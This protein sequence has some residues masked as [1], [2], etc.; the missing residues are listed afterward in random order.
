VR[1]RFAAAAALLLLGACT[2]PEPD[3]DERQAYEAALRDDSPAG[4]AADTATPAAVL[5]PLREAERASGGTMG[6]AAIHLPTGR[7]IALHGGDRF[8]MASTFKLAVALA[9]LARVDSGRIR[10]DQPVTIVPADFRLGPQPLA[11]SVGRRGGTVTV[12]QM[13]RSM[14]VYSDNLA[15]DKLM[16]MAGGPAAVDAHLRGRGIDGI[17][18]DRYEAEVHW[19]YAGVRHVPPEAEW[20]LQRFDSVTSAVPPAQKDSAHAAF[21]ADPRDTATPDAFVQL[22]G[23]VAEGRGLSAASRRF[24]LD[25]MQASVTGLRRIRGSLPESTTVA[26]KTGTIGSSAND[27]GLMTLP[28]GSQVAI[29]VLVKGSTRPTEAVEPAIARAARVVYDHFAA[30]GTGTGAGT[31]PR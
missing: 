26:D 5:N 25:A 17:R 15:T 12:R 3:R 23:Q 21:F 16:R 1:F 22:L 11:D 8:P 24:L 10:L 18:V 2:V 13:V 6:V 29:A 14:M 28:D 9:V 30:A 27:V 20:T 7:R 4:S 19:Q 31:A